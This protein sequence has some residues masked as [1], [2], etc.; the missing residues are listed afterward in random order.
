MSLINKLST[1]QKE[2][3]L[4]DDELKYVLMI[5]AEATFSGKDVLVVSEIVNKIQNKLDGQ[6]TNKLG[7]DSR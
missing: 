4:S 5:I 2:S 6:A 1:K 3:L 7:P